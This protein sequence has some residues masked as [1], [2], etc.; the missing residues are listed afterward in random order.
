MVNPP[1][2]V[3]LLLSWCRLHR[4]P[5]IAA[6]TRVCGCDCWLCAMS[7]AFREWDGAGR[8]RFLRCWVHVCSGLSN[9]EAE[10]GW[11]SEDRTAI[12]ANF[13][14]GRTDDRP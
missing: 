11:N 3:V 10:F 9:T 5:P 14:R 1:A 13:E 6:W 8:L 12:A 7:F 4:L 2:Q